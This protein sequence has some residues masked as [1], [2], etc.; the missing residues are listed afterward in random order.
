M[1]VKPPAAPAGRAAS[2]LKLA[3][4]TATATTVGSLPTH[5]PTCPLAASRRDSAGHS[6][7]KTA[8]SPLAAVYRA[9]SSRRRLTG[10]TWR[11]WRRART[12]APRIRS[13]RRL[14][15][16]RWMGAG[17]TAGCLIPRSMRWALEGRRRDGSGHSLT[18]IVM[19]LR[20]QRGKGKKGKEEMGEWERGK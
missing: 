19:Y 14:R 5:S 1:T 2:P 20:S 17:I 4:L 13:A 7:T 11:R 18:R 9:A 15:P 16:A 10:S 12:H 8:T 6:T 3:P